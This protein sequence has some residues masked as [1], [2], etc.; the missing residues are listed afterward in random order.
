VIQSVEFNR[1]IGI[2]I[3]QLDSNDSEGS[4]CQWRQWQ[5]WNLAPQIYK[6]NMNIRV[7]RRRN[8]LYKPRELNTE[9]L[10]WYLQRYAVPGC[11]RKRKIYFVL[12]I[13]R[14]YK[15]FS[16]STIVLFIEEMETLRFIFSH[17]LQEQNLFTSAT[18]G[19]FM[20][21]R[22]AENSEWNERH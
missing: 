7:N 15:E 21:H 19:M 17:I 13:T 20:I 6:V 9:N 11:E 18:F 8:S 2:S 12:Q 4:E 3:S 10:T 5:Q 16:G 22:D 1:Q 14:C